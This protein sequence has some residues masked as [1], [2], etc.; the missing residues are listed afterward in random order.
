MTTSLLLTNGYIHSISEPY[1]NALHADN[2]VVAWLGSD[3][4]AE[5]L[6]AATVSGPVNT[7]DLC[8]ALVTPAFIDGYSTSPITSGDARSMLSST[9][10]GDERIYYAP[11]GA[12]PSNADGLF[13]ASGQINQLPETLASLKPPTQLLIQSENS[14]QLDHILGALSQQSNAV[15]MRSRH[16][17]LANHTMSAQQISQLV[18]LHASVTI[19]PAHVESTP[20][21]F[22]PTASLIA[23][24]VHVAM[25]TGEWSG[26]LWK[27]VTALIENENTDQRISTRAAFNTVSRDAVRALPS[28]IAQAN[29]GAGQVAV[30]APANFNVWQA[31]QLGVQA[32]NVKA[33]HWSTDKRAGTALLPILSS[34]D[35]PP[36]LQFTIRNG[37]IV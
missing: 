27:L 26:S 6:V 8:G 37:Q 12:D 13:V 30:G 4:T 18:T 19:V 34:T 28:R 15:L 36:E 31:R 16:R 23:A 25:G 7:K 33:A 29:M 2:S 21:I 14:E 9:V 10:P 17:V 20:K 22:A 32:P 3:E 24:G 5:R 1:A 11:L 35:D